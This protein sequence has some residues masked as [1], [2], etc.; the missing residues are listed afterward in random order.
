MP[1]IYNAA[2]TR[3]DLR[4]F[5]E[6]FL[7][8]LETD[9]AKADAVRFNRTIFELEEKH[10]AIKKTLA[11]REYRSRLVQ[12]YVAFAKAIAGRT[13]QQTSFSLSAGLDLGVYRRTSWA[14][15]PSSEWEQL[16]NVAK[17][18]MKHEFVLDSEF[19]FLITIWSFIGSQQKPKII[20]KSAM[21]L[22]EECGTQNIIHRQIASAYAFSGLS[23]K[24]DV[25]DVNGHAITV[26]VS[27]FLPKLSA[28]IGKQWLFWIQEQIPV[29]EEVN[30]PSLWHAL[31]KLY[32][33]GKK[34]VRAAA[35]NLVKAIYARIAHRDTRRN[36][37]HGTTGTLIGCS[38]LLTKCWNGLSNQ[39]IR[40]VGGFALL[41]WYFLGRL[42]RRMITA[43]RG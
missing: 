1:I 33:G 24:S 11:S 15:L 21:W 34:S 22:Y 26:A 40:K 41:F 30:L 19:L 32:F 31:V 25:R 4:E 9:A 12:S 36:L 3:G 37:L 17:E 35:L 39:Q 10:D 2:L 42:T 14:G 8:K 6:A 13:T 23:I 38:A 16:D 27:L 18:A 5:A 29:T 7:N 20:D 28:A 43:C